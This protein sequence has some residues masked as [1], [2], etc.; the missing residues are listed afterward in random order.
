[1]FFGS[2][3]NNVQNTT[4]YVI[5]FPYFEHFF[6]FFPVK[7]FLLGCFWFLMDYLHVGVCSFPSSF[8]ISKSSFRQ[9]VSYVLLAD[10]DV[11]KMFAV[12]MPTFHRGPENFKKSKPKKLVKSNKSISWK[13]FPDRIP[14]F[15]ISK[16]AKNQFLN[17][18]KFLNCQKSNFTKKTFLI[19]FY[20][21]S[22]LPGFF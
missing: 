3:Y 18:E 14:F 4:I 22:F 17:W 5:K 19:F 12:Q 8:F 9:G 21:R 20:F 7:Y 13:N 10:S 11:E 16:M 2:V 6:N 15:D 1:M